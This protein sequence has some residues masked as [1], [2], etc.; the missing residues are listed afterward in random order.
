MSLIAP[1]GGGLGGIIPTIAPET[2]VPATT[3]A[4]GGLAD[5]AASHA[6]GLAAHQ[7]PDHPVTSDQP[8]SLSAASDKT[9]SSKT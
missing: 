7:T 5:G 9:A 2:G 4:P 3:P 6:T 1:G 8:Q